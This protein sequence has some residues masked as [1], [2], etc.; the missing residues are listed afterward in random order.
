MALAG[1]RVTKNF[2]KSYDAAI[3]PLQG[4]IE[5][6]VHDFV[7][8]FRANPTRCLQSYDRVSGRK[9]GFLEIDVAG[10]PRLIAALREDVLYL[11]DTGDHEITKRW[12]GR[13]M[14]KLSDAEP[15]PSQFLP[16]SPT[17]FFSRVPNK[18]RSHFANEFDPEWL[19]FLDAQQADVLHTILDRVQDGL[20]GRGVG[21]FW[22][23]GGPGTGKTCLLLNLLKWAID[24][25]L[26]VSIRL[27][28]PVADYIQRS[29][30]QPLGDVVEVTELADLDTSGDR[31]H[32]DLL[33]VDDPSTLRAMRM[34]MD[35]VAD[36]TARFVV[37]GFD[38]LQMRESLTDDEFTELSREYDVSVL[39]L[40][41]CYR[42]K[43]HVGRASAKVADAIAASTPFLAHDKIER[44]RNDREDLTSLANQL[45]FPNPKGYVDV[46]LG[47]TEEHVAAEVRRILG[48]DPL[49]RHWPPLLVVF[50]EGLSLPGGWK[51]EWS[52]VRCVEAGLNSL[53]RLKGI[54]CQHCFMIIGRELYEA[55]ER[56][57]KGS[58]Q[59]VYNERRLLRIPFSRAKD[60]IVTFVVDGAAGG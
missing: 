27:S 9:D 5:G 14:P 22:I 58:G 25:K 4:C 11:L 15:A 28:Q 44:Y 3:A 30:G 21:V 49:W 57:F 34:G 46:H 23:V 47:A 59:S 36:R 24:A 13:R 54:E 1:V 50:D 12:A 38:P 29:L 8:S 19:Y 39:R 45:R 16:E 35:R 52:H 41:T 17:G 51:R 6:A 60:S 2:T 56:G 31:D 20:L 10:G 40:H 33:L 37:V 48:G 55:V 42:Q 18:G 43:E 26:K 32:L 53:E 7:R